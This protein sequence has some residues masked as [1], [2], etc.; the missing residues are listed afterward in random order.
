MN[1]VLLCTVLYCLLPLCWGEW[2]GK[3][4]AVDEAKGENHRLN[5]YRYIEGRYNGRR[6]YQ[7]HKDNFF[8]FNKIS[9]N[10]YF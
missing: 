2:Q 3:D 9:L 1:R 6:F 5:I 4:C 8:I 10:F 7:Y